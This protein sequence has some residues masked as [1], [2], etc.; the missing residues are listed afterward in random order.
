M[1]YMS[2]TAGSVVYMTGGTTLVGG[3]SE[4]TMSISMSTVET[5]SFADQWDTAVPSTRNASGSFTGSWDPADSAQ[6]SMVN[7]TLGGS[8]VALR[9]YT[10]GTSYWNIGTAYLESMETSI[11]QKGKG[12]LNFNFKAS[13]P[14]TKVG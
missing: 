7:A 6:S 2:G 14:V 5:T 4:W 11:S 1:A 8:A 12:E 9:L 10:A 3:L 13:G